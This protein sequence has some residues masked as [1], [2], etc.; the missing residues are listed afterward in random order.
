RTG[1]RLGDAGRRGRGSAAC[2]PPPARG[3]ACGRARSGANRVRLVQPGHAGARSQGLRGPRLAGGRGDPLRHVPAHGGRR[4]RGP[5]GARGGVRRRPLPPGRS[6]ALGAHAPPGTG[7]W[8]TTSAVIRSCVMRVLRGPRFAFAIAWLATL[9]ALAAAQVEAPTDS[10]MLIV[11]EV[12]GPV[13]HER[14]YFIPMGDSIL[15][16]AVCERNYNDSTGTPHPYKKTMSVVL[17]SRDLGLLRYL[18]VQD[19]D[20]H[21]VERGVLPG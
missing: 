18:S 20:G 9:P 14:S 17:D 2:G 10:A 7:H 1:R 12:D 19:F 6:G 13:A 16:S 3:R 21:S 4:A 11:F 15:V 5:A 8:P